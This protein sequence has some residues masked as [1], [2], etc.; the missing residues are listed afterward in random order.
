MKSRSSLLAPLLLALAVPV[1]SLAAPP[2]TQAP[3]AL[4][5]DPTEDPLLISAGFLNGHPD[6][7]F[8]MLGMEKQRANDLQAAFGFFQRAGFY[9]D[10]VSQAMVAEM[11]WNGTGTAVNRPLA[12]AWMD[13]AA[14]RGYKGF[15]ELR[16]RYWAALSEAEQVQAVTEGEAVYARFGDAAAEPR[17]A[18][19]MRREQKRMTGSRTGFA[20]NV[21]IL[22]PGP[23]GTTEQ[24]DGTKFYDSRYWDP[25]QY[26]QWQDTIWSTPRVARVDVGS[27]TQLPAET[28]RPS[29]I[30]E[31]AP[32]PDAPEPKTDDAQPQPI[33]GQH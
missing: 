26:R 7:R 33:P 15:L 14:E 12:Y 10:K 32:Q 13:L 20:G 21:K 3:S 16:E 23:N 1:T 25:A 30:P 24:I 27:V 17:L 9:G 2:A 31:V 6:L 22:V 11:L 29:R 28:G 5:S 19:A 8:R 18:L 4:P